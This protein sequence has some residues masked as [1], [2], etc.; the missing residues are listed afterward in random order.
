MNNFEFARDRPWVPASLLCNGY[1]VLLTPVVKRVEDETDHS[2]L[3]S[4]ENK[5]AWGY[6]S[7]HPYVFM[8]WYL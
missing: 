1:R 2:P 7:T 6:T 5:N 8:T 4:A 3:S